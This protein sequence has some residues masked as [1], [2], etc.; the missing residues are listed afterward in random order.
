MARR[1]KDD[2]VL[3]G[4]FQFARL[5]PWWLGVAL[6]VIA[7]VFLHRY[8][9]VPLP[10]PT[11]V[12]SG[13]IGDMVVGQLFKALAM[14]GQYLV[15]LA[16]LGGAIASYLGKRKRDQLAHNVAESKHGDALRQ[17][18][19]RE[20]EML[21]GQAFRMRGY[22]VTETGGGGADG[23]ID[24]QLRKGSE[25]FVVQCKQWKAY[26]V[27]VSVVRELYGVMASQGADGGFVVTSGVFTEDAKAFAKGKNVTLI[28]GIALTALIKQARTTAPTALATPGE[29]SSP[30]T[31]EPSCPRCGSA[32][33]RRK[34]KRGTNAGSEFWGCIAYP[35]CRGTREL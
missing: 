7:Y 31:T 23:G 27:S 5:L 30:S 29:Q 19:W 22:T 16:L 15:P 32:M 12:T 14:V 33:V 6:A 13:Q 9:T 18:T 35:E 10:A 1:R 4:L 26:K 11:Q 24:L 2:N 28:D 20:F 3:E 17:M 8:A 25:R 34:A 21:V